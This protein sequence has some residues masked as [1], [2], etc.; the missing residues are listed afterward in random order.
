HTEMV[1]DWRVIKEKRA[2]FI[3]DIASN[4][5]RKNFNLYFENLIF[6]GDWVDTKLPST[7]E[8]AVLSG[9]FAAEKVISSLKK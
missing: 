9:K 1:V 8:S 2:T 4:Y 7:I 5:I 3:P 6:A